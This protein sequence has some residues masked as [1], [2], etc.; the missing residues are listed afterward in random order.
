[1]M[2]ALTLAILLLSHS[3]SAF[4]SQLAN[5]NIPSAGTALDRRAL[6]TQGG[7]AAASFLVLPGASLASGVSF[8]EAAKNAEKYRAK[9]TCKPQTPENCTPAFVSKDSPEY[10]DY[11]KRKAAR[12]KTEQASLTTMLN[13]KAFDYDTAK[14]VKKR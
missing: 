4:S 3:A 11:L 6:L 13:A 10:K 5:R 9:P 8:E 7:L 14:D 2:R 12:D 1:M